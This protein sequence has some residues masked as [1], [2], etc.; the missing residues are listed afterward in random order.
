MLPRTQVKIH[1][2]ASIHITGEADI[3]FLGLSASQTGLTSNIWAPKRP[4]L[5]EGGWHLRNHSFTC[6]CTCSHMCTYTHMFTCKY[7]CDPQVYLGTHTCTS[8]CIHMYIH[9]QIM[10]VG[11]MCICTWLQTHIDMSVGHIC[12]YTYVYTHRNSPMDMYVHTHTPVN[13]MFVY[14]C[15]H[16]NINMP[17]GD[18]FLLFPVSGLT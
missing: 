7:T 15:V 14:I 3:G 16:T 18:K 13:H 2:C 12:T 6:M 10:P 8:V 9:T 5:N 17:V 11:H 4:F 1:V